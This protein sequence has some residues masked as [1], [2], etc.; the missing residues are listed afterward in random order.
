MRAEA[1]AVVI[2]AGIVGCSVAEHLTRLGWR[3]V[4]VV[5][6][7]PLFQTGGSTS[8]AP[9][10]VFQV[11]PSQTMTRLA[12]DTVERLGRLRHD[13]QSC[14]QAVGGIE[15]AATPQR[16]QWLKI[17]HGLAT[18][19]GVESELITPR[20]VATRVRLLD[21]DRIHG[22]LWVPSDGIAD[23]VRGVEAMADLARDRGA[24]FHGDT[25]VTGIEVS[26][27]RVR[28]VDTS[29]GRIET[30]CV[31]CCAGMWGPAVGR[32]AG[33][34]IPLVPMQH[35]YVRTAPVAE[36]AGATREAEEPILRHQDSS[37]YFRR[38]RDR[39]GVGSYQ[40]TPLPVPVE[41][42]RRPG[43]SPAMPSVMPFTENDFKQPWA[44][45]QE[46][47]PPL[48]AVEI[49]QPLNGLFSFTPD[50]MPLIGESRRVRGFWVAEAVWITHG[51]AVGK[52]MAE[53]I[54]EGAPGVDL[55][56]C[57]LHRFEPFAHS[58]AYV[59]ERAWQ[60]YDEVY[61]IHHPMEPA[62]GPRPL[63]T[64]P[65]HQRQKDLGAYFNEANGW[66][67]PQW[68]EA[69]ADLDAV[70]RV[71]RRDEWAGR[72]WSPIE[73]AEHLV[74]RER[75]GLYDMTSLKR[76]EVTGPGALAFLRRLTTGR[77][78]R[79]PGYVTY[80]LMLDDRGGIRSDTTVARL[81]EHRFQV[82]LN[83]PRDVDWM[84]RNLPAD[85]SVAVRDITGGTCCVGVWGPRAREV[86]QQLTDDDFSHDG[87]GLF[88]ARETFVR[89]VPVTA[90]R[91]SY[92][93]ELGWELYT[94]AEFGLRLWDL[95]WE[96]GQPH[97]IVA[98]GRGAFNSLR[99][100][101]GYRAWGTDMWSEHDPW[102]A[103]LGFAVKLDAGGGFIGREAVERRRR[104]GATHRL[105]CLTIDD[106][107]VVMGDEPV[108]ADGRAVGFV[109]SAAYGHTLGRSIAY[110]WLPAELAA[111]GTSVQVEYL[112]ERHPAT[113]SPDPLF[114][115][116]MRR[117]RA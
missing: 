92:V 113:V 49:E 12:G 14:F 63:R 20:Q 97:G 34:P 114:D 50:G 7:G 116:S 13:G 110:A 5:E 10:L 76:V 52:V 112:A 1:R 77:L 82:G 83:G 108:H 60:Q 61:D 95:L 43:E 23:A 4:A 35:Q 54:V 2:G 78:D 109:T 79:P 67:R 94:S 64:S 90:L 103:G 111:E 37:L 87:F 40:H 100:E 45:A 81:G 53:W 21:P 17:K 9:G 41:A 8:H 86:V 84:L 98:G 73:G 65:F 117:M 89:D 27:G 101:K 115:P 39:Y 80:A 69:N 99:L 3:D 85:H 58:P 105:S 28:A 16:W 107:V 57:D 70:R 26:D 62:G 18:S 96:A 66:E 102:A 33:V 30:G 24:R 46:L 55:R 75:V 48:R 36:L 22:G 88:R 32:M 6:Q 19:W 42:L 106:G 29:R 51:P 44:D 15:V 25:E 71:P 59:H 11:N 93:G 104:D 31:V 68:F 56:E 38:H 91:L 74:T 72:H 47:L